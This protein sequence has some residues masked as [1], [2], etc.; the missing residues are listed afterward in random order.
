MRLDDLRHALREEA[1]ETERWELPPLSH[2]A[3]R[4]PGRRLAAVALVAAAVV[5]VL[6]LPG[7]LV[8]GP[9]AD[10][11]AEPPATATSEPRLAELAWE[12][13]GPVCLAMSP[14]C[15]APR[16]IRADDVRLRRT[17]L[18]E[19]DALT[20]DPTEPAFR[21]TTVGG[22]PRVVYLLVGAVG[23]A[24]GELR[25]DPGFGTPLD[26]PA[27]EPYLLRVTSTDRN[28]TVEVTERSPTSG[29]RLV[30]AVY[31]PVP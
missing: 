9:V 23:A 28:V 24:D 3:P 7:L 21:R 19:S 1:H 13:V 26:R 8:P 30:T 5:A 27:S 6:L 4:H 20:G 17:L 16:S 12:P 14:E 18:S 22:A 29:E 25:I 15:L 10:R 11:E 2:T 31:E